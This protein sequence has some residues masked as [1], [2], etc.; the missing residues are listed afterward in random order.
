MFKLDLIYAGWSTQK[1]RNTNMP[2]C[3]I[4]IVLEIIV[5]NLFSLTICLANF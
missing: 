1:Y 5:T 4:H 2:S 3:T